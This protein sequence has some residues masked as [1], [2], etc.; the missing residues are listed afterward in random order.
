M[1]IEEMSVQ[2]LLQYRG[3]S[4]CPADLDSYWQAA[5]TEMHQ[6]D[7]QVELIPADFTASF[8]ECF[9]LYF[10]GVRGA[11]IHAKLLRP[12][13]I[14]GPCPALLEF[15]GYMGN[16][17]D[18][19]SKLAYVAAGFVVV[20]MDCR[21]QGGFSEDAGAV[22]GGTVHGH[23]IRGLN[24]QPE[25]MLYRQIFL[26]TA[27]LAGLVMAMDQVDENR[28]GARGFSQGGALTL[29]C[30]ALEPRIKRLLPV[31]PFL[32][33]Y[34]RVWEMDLETPAYI[35]LRQYFRL[36]DPLHQREE[37]I[38]TRL[39]YIDVQNLVSRIQGQTLMAITMRD[40]L[41]PPSTQFAAYNKI[42]APKQM[43]LY[44]DHGHE[45]LPQI[46]D[47]AFRF[48]SSFLTR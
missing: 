34:Q 47:H 41:C 25:N 36:F 1:R 4:P 13:A 7:P 37:Q 24:D 21:G 29:A 38:F 48:F 3:K 42:R 23:I 33:D 10:T 39:G 30:A 46:E 35:E 43:L 14:T 12:R 19:Y 15:H 27:Q 9:D 20:A 5:L 16:C 6:V 28:V 22:K 2:E 44:N 8:A 40:N 18:W 17:G 45:T 32:S 26:D 31:Y 11:R